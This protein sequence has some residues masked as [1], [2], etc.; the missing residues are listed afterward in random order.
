M[1]LG[2]QKATGNAEITVLADRGYFNRE[3]VL[4][5]RAPVFCPV[6]PRR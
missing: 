3:E 6:C 1:A 4:L 5:A 2:A